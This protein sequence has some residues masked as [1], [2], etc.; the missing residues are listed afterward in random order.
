[1]F[2][3]IVNQPDIIPDEVR[4]KTLLFNTFFFNKLTSKSKP[5]EVDVG[6]DRYHQK[7]KK[8]LRHDDIF[9]KD[10]LIVPVNRSHHWFLLIVCYHNLVT[11]FVE[12]DVAPL[13]Q[14]PQSPCIIIMDSLGVVRNGGRFKLTDPLR[15]L[16]QS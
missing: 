13:G 9:S 16:L 10:F 12:V 1:M 8:W 3:Y 2:S 14:N 11:E 5:N 7:V 4:E 6:R 15:N